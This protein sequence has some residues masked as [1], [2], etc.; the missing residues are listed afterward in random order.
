MR[1]FRLFPF[2]GPIDRLLSYWLE[3]I[4]PDLWQKVYKRHPSS[5]SELLPPPDTGE[6]EPGHASG[7]RLFAESDRPRDTL[8]QD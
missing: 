8:K 2:A 7:D 4:A 1:R 6:G 5:Q 3:A